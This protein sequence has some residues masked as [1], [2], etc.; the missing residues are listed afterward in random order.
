MRGAY[1]SWQHQCVHP[2]S[3]WLG[4]IQTSRWTRNFSRLDNLNRDHLR[5]IFFYKGR[6]AGATAANTCT[7]TTSTTTTTTTYP[8]CTRVRAFRP[9]FC[10]R[11]ERKAEGREGRVRSREAPGLPRCAV[12][13]AVRGHPCVRRTPLRPTGEWARRKTW[14]DDNMQEGEHAC[15]QRNGQYMAPSLAPER[16]SQR[17]LKTDSPCACSYSWSVKEPC[18]PRRTSCSKF[19]GTFQ[20]QSTEGGGAYQ[21][22]RVTESLDHRPLIA[23][24]PLSRWITVRAPT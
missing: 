11:F 17:V 19:E 3:A 18:W 20:R 16:P 4:C 13:P 15:M 7:K 5:V 21:I 22:G 8:K 10:G 23:N 2:L 9:C 6:V 1:V 24:A 14:R 12:R